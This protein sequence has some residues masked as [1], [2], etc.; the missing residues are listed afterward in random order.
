MVA[1]PSEVAPL[2]AFVLA[3]VPDEAGFPGVLAVVSGE[4]P[5]AVSVAGSR[6][7][8]GAPLERTLRLPHPVDL[9]LTLGPLRRG[10]L[11]P[12]MRIGPQG[13]WRASRTPVGPATTHLTAGGGEIS[14][15]A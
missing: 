15:R 1:E 10:R 14:A 4:G 5:V 12:T 8:E 7:V 11:D 2:T 6:P 3:D 13:V 9:R